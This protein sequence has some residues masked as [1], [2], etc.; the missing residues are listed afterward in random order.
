[1]RSVLIVRGE[2]RVVRRRQLRRL[3]MQLGVARQALVVHTLD[4]RAGQDVVELVEQHLAPDRGQPRCR[5]GH[6]GEG[7]GEHGGPLQ[8][9][10]RQLH[11]P[12]VPLVARL[13]RQRA[14]VALQVQLARPGGEARRIGLPALEECGGPFLLHRAEACQILDAR[15]PLQ[16]LLAGAAAAIA[17]A[18]DHQR[19]ARNAVVLVVLL[20]L[21]HRARRGRA[22]VGLLGQHVRQ[23]LCAV[24]AL[25]VE[26]VVR[27]GV[28]Q[29]PGELLR[30]EVVHAAFF[31]IWGSAPV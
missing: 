14:L 31:R 3:P 24:D 11:L 5:V 19:M 8:L 10:Q 20:D 21:A 30:R 4:R 7:R 25:P 26:G 18:E 23:H 29:A 16:V 6:A 2:P 12:V 15:Q 17:D 1:M 9:A 28:D 22:V 13:G 27:E